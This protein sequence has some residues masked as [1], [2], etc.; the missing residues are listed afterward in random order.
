MDL[1]WYSLT[2]RWLTMGRG[3]AGRGTREGG[4]ESG[5]EGAKEMGVVLVG[6]WEHLGWEVGGKE[7]ALEEACKGR[8]CEKERQKQKQGV[9]GGHERRREDGEWIWQWRWEGGN[10]I[11]T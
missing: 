8:G 2:I 10:E 6:C 11:A 7:R 4:G 3:H 5:G 1:T 9:W